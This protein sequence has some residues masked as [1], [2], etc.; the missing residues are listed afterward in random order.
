MIVSDVQLFVSTLSLIQLYLENGDIVR[1][2]NF[3]VARMEVD[4][5]YYPNL[6][7]VAPGI[8]VVIA[9]NN[10]QTEGSG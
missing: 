1:V 8:Q 4:C 6:F 9:S 5:L 3:R 2:R 7:A 10:Y